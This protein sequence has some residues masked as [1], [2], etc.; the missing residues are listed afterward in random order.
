MPPNPEP[1]PPVQPSNPEPSALPSAIAPIEPEPELEQVKIKKQRKPLRE[2]ARWKLFGK[3]TGA[4]ALVI[5]L[6]AGGFW[7]FEHHTKAADPSTVLRDALRQA[8]TTKQVSIETTSGPNDQTTNFDFT[9]PT[10]LTTSSTA[11]VAINGSNFE[12]KGYGSLKDS[13]FSYSKFPLA[14][15]SKLSSPLTN[16]WI[17]VRTKGAEP[18][19]VSGVIYQVADPHYQLI[20]PVVF[21]NFTPAERDAL[22]KFIA[23]NTIY[24]F[25]GKQGGR[26][27]INGH[28]VLTY[29]V[30]LNT[31]SL[32]VLNQNAAL[33]EGI[34]PNDIQA[35]I[36]H[37]TT[38]RGAQLTL[39]I[40]SSKHQL[41]RLTATKSGQTTTYDYSNFGSAQIGNEPQTQATWEGFS[42][43]QL[44]IEQQAAA[45]QS[46]AGLD[47]SR[48]ADLKAVHKYL[49]TFYS[50][51]NFYPLIVELSNQGWVQG[52]IKGADP[53][54]FRDPMSSSVI[55]AAQPTANAYA[56][57]TT[58]AGC[59]NTPLNPCLHYT[60]TATLTTGKTYSLTD[61]DK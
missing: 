36:D 8:M 32:L 53:D 40:D 27:V 60:I 26:D 5:I 31:G 54:I 33:S 6:A 12:L 25:D 22:L 51:N 19:G 29:Q 48:Q 13:Y 37:L 43:Y 23:D 14:I 61:L 38:L 9:T 15:D 10:D 58:P 18:A 20:G 56:Y 46:A 49:A 47:A 41:I 4:L 21:G 52:S 57:Q 3:I 59:D 50:N 39:A 24:S 45:R 30:T 42:P 1:T 55:L 34:D 7:F 17:H 2:Q 35:A 28:H 16:A 44:Q 11:T